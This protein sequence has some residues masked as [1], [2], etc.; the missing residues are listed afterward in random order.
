VKKVKLIKRRR[1]IIVDAEESFVKKTRKSSNEIQEIKITSIVMI[2]RRIDVFEDEIRKKM[3]S[4]MRV[5]SSK[6][7]SQKFLRSL[8]PSL[9][10]DRKC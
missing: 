5:F 6:T 3:E 10:K 1:E 8:I 2:S 9:N 7:H 4:E